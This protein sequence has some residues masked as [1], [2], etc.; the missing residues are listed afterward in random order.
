MAK[1]NP[2]RLWLTDVPPDKTFWCH[3][4]RLLRNL[5]ELASGLQEMSDD[6]YWYHVSDEKN[7]FATWTRDVIG[8]ITLAG[9]I[10]RAADRTAAARV[11]RARLTRHRAST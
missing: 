11:V 7:D 6:T 5:D 8:D 1:K 3:D 2:T 9:N 4:S 10:R